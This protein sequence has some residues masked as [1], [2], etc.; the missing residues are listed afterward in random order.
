ML[1]P[2]ASLASA[3]PPPVQLAQPDLVERDG[4]RRFRSAI[5]RPSSAFGTSRATIRAVI[6]G[7]GRNGGQW[8]VPSGWGVF[9][10]LTS[11]AAACSTIGTTATAVAFNMLRQPD[12][13]G[14]RLRF[15]STT[16]RPEEGPGSGPVPWTWLRRTS[17]RAAFCTAAP[18]GGQPR[19]SPQACRNPAS[20]CPAVIQDLGRAA[21][22]RIRARSTC[23]LACPATREGKPVLGNRAGPVGSPVGGTNRSPEVLTLVREVE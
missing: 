21:T 11:G 18:D 20:R 7:R 9:V 14:A 19:R 8:A 1:V 16:I 2:S 10:P 6:N 23:I 4:V 5:R 13:E 22:P 12:P 3:R 17:P 15:P